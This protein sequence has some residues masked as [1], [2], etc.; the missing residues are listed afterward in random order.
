MSEEIITA[1]AIPK[2]KEEAPE[3]SEVDET[4]EQYQQQLQEVQEKWEES[5]FGLTNTEQERAAENNGT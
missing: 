4:P 5:V 3:G 2:E 1:A